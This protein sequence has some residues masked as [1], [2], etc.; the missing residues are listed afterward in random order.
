MWR[1]HHRRG[2]LGPDGRHRRTPLR[3]GGPIA[4]ADQAAERQR[5]LLCCG[6]TQAFA[7][8]IGLIPPVSSSQS[9]TMTEALVR[10]PEHEQLPDS[11][12]HFAPRSGLS[13]PLRLHRAKLRSPVSPFRATTVIR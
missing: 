4:Q 1:R 13:F 9:S 12:A 10:T 3:A 11:L 8:D 6:D 2:R 7:R 5:Q